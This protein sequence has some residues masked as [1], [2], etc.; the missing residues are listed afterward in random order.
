MTKKMTISPKQCRAA[1]A[2]TDLSQSD[3][4]DTAGVGRSTVADF[5]RG[6]RIPTPENLDAIRNTLEAAG[7][8]FIDENGGGVGVRLRK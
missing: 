6:A 8:E 7:I 4:A 3:L 1:R 5:E 2:L